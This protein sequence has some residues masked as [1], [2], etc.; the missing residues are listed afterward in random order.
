MNAAL[1]AGDLSAARAGEVR[2]QMA[3]M[4]YVLGLD[5]VT[6]AE[7]AIPAEVTAMA[8]ERQLCRSTKNFARADELRAAIT[9]CGYEVRD[10]AGGFKLVP[11]R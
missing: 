7:D 10:V 4:V 3:D 5:A 11:T 6:K 8:E 2:S 1:A 9:E